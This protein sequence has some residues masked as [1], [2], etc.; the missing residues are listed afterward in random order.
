M[1]TE[2]RIDKAIEQIESQGNAQQLLEQFVAKN[3]ALHDYFT[4]DSEVLFEEEVDF[5]YGLFLTLLFATDTLEVEI[6]L[7]SFQELEE[8]NWKTFYEAKNLNASFDLYFANY[9]EEDLLAYVEDATMA[10]QDDEDFAFLTNVGKEWIVVKA[11][12]YIDYFIKN[13]K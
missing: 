6:D 4:A 10:E 7:E 5:F 8:G 11:K 2:A 1:I 12:T 13:P 3:S 9:P